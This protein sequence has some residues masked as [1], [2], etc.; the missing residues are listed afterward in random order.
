V[1]VLLGK[2]RMIT[3]KKYWNFKKKTLHKRERSFQCN[4]AAT[5]VFVNSSNPISKQN[6]FSLGDHFLHMYRIYILCLS[7]E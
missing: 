5:D 4:C 6:V 1:I 3:I 7:L 2:E